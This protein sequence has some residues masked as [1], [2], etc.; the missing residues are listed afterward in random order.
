MFKILLAAQINPVKVNTIKC[1]F[2][3]TLFYLSEM[4]SWSLT[5]SLV[6]STQEM[7]LDQ[8]CLAE[9]GTAHPRALHAP[10]VGPRYVILD[11]G[12]RRT[13]LPL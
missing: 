1:F 9:P 6:F 11:A 10:A 12:Y 5:K 2:L 8:S 13:V 7:S 4:V 3:R